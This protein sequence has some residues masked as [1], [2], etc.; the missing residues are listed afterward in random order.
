MPTDTKL[1]NLIINDLTE[2]QYKG[3]TPNEN[4]LYLTPDTSGGNSSKYYA[5]YITIITKS[6]KPTSVFTIYLV[7]KDSSAYTNFNDF[8][9]YLPKNADFSAQGYFKTT[10]DTFYDISRLSINSMANQ[11]VTYYYTYLSDFNDV[12][13]SVITKPKQTIDTVQLDAIHSISDQ[14]I[15]L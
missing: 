12:D 15:E 2:E 14:V 6:N 4:E 3:L 8:K 1:Q 7:T 10:D 13:T 9:K 11:L 5:H